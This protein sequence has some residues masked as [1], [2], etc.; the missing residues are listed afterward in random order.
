MADKPKTYAQQVQ[1][2]KEQKEELL[3]DIAE[4]Q[5]QVEFIPELQQEIS[6]LKAQLAE[7]SKED[8]QGAVNS[9]A[10]MVDLL[11]RAES[12]EQGIRNLQKLNQDLIL[13]KDSLQQQLDILGKE[14]DKNRGKDD[15]LNL[16][17]E[18]L[19]ASNL[20]VAVLNQQLR[21]AQVQYES[22]EKSLIEEL[23]RV[24]ADR[25]LLNRTSMELSQRV[26]D[27]I[28]EIENLKNDFSA[29]LTVL[30][31]ENKSLKG[32]IDHF[33]S[34]LSKAPDTLDQLRQAVSGS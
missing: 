22:N 17:S 9:K 16:L 2:L 27:K 29:R 34:L 21:D 14:R 20:R 26:A 3:T 31:N 23:R 6:D 10:Q 5:R 28:V 4:F 8:R 1:D 24:R 11:Q 32:K 19:K 25:E 15:K 33:N 30:F 13:E 18:E 7:K 12:A